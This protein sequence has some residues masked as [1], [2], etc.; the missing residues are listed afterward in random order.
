MEFVSEEISV[1]LR[2]GDRTLDTVHYRA[3]SLLWA[4][5]LSQIQTTDWDTAS[6]TFMSGF[7]KWAYIASGSAAPV[8]RISVYMEN[9]VPLQQFLLISFL[10]IF[11]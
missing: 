3:Y 6:P 5:F 11:L 4:A 2:Y 1:V 7:Q 8:L 9:P 10:K